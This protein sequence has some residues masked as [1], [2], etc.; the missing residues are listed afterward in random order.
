M[1]EPVPSPCFQSPTVPCSANCSRRDQSL[2]EP[3]PTPNSEKVG[4]GDM[5][6]K[7]FI[8]N[9][10]PPGESESNE[11]CLS[12][13]VHVLSSRRCIRVFQHLQTEPSRSRGAENGGFSFIFQRF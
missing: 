8:D 9:R 4:L 6:I 5:L 12:S 3:A 13:T 11:R 7:S 10:S 1:L 2:Q